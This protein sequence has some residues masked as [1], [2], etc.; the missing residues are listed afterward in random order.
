LTPLR[1]VGLVCFVTICHVS[2]RVAL[3]FTLLDDA[4]LVCFALV[5]FG[6]LPF[7]PFHSFAN[8]RPLYFVAFTA[9]PLRLLLSLPL[10]L[11]TFASLPL[12]TSASLRFAPLAFSCDRFHVVFCLMWSVA[13][14]FLFDVA[15]SHADSLPLYLD[16]SHHLSTVRFQPIHGKHLLVG[17]TFELVEITSKLVGKQLQRQAGLEGKQL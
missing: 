8:V 11:V 13:F 17:G 16:I 3:C 14:V 7:F 9:L 1:L 6:L 4:C 5:C 15:S 10:R 2:S 12:V